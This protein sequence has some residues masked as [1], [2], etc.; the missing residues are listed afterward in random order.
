MNRKV[1]IWN[2]H[3][4]NKVKL[5]TPKTRKINKLNKNYVWRWAQIHWQW[6]I[7]IDEELKYETL[8]SLNY[9][10]DEDYLKKMV[11]SL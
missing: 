9:C 4:L 8:S 3:I 1:L 2:Q 6:E 10:D 11:A 5:K 7:T